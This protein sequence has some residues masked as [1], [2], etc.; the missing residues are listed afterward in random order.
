[1]IESERN[2]HNHWFYLAQ[3][4]LDEHKYLIDDD[5][6]I[7]K[8]G[9]ADFPKGRFQKLGTHYLA[10]IDLELR[11]RSDAKDLERAVETYTQCLQLSD[12]CPDAFTKLS[13]EKILS[14]KTDNR[15]MNANSYNDLLSYIAN[16]VGGMFF[17][18]WAEPGPSR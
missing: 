7:I 5:H 13:D 9:I 4:L 11:S 2:P 15:L 3:V 12:K 1:M 14:T 18:K 17:D 16:R 8:Y 6:F 10:L